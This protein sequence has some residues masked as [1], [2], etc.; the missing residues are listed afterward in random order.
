VNDEVSFG[1]WIRRRRKSLDLTQKQLAERV[2]CAT[3]TIVKIEADERRPSREIAQLLAERLEIPAE[4]RS[5]F[6]RVARRERRVA[7]L[8]SPDVSAATLRSPVSAPATSHLPVPPTPLIG[9]ERELTAIHQMLHD[10]HCRLLTLTGPGGMGKT[11]LALETARQIAQAATSEEHSF[12]DGIHFVSLAP[13]SS[14]E[15]V[16][17]AIG[18]AIG[19]V[20]SESSALDVQLLNY[21]HSKQMLLV[22]DN[23]EHLLDSA[24]TLAEILRHASAIRVLVTSRER[25]NLQGEWVFEV[26]GL[27]VPPECQADRLGTYSAVTLFLQ[28]AQRVRPG[29]SLTPDECPPIVHIC[30][31]VEGMPLGIEL[32]AAWV[33]VLSCG[34]IAQ[35]IQRNLD[36]LTTSAR[37]VP[38]RHRSLQATMDHSW[39]LLSLDERGVLSRLSVF[40]GSF[41][42]E[43]AEQVAGATLPLLSALVDKSLLRR[44]EAGRYDLHELI[45]QYAQEQLMQ[46]GDF[47]D[48]RDRHLT[49]FLKFAEEA[50]PKLRDAK[51]LI[52]LDLLEQDHDNLRAALDWS[53]RN[54]ETSPP[55]SQASLRLAGTLYVFWKRRDHWSEGREWLQRA[56]AQSTDLPA[57]REYVRALNAAVQLA[58]EQADTRWAHQLAEENLALSREMGDTYSLACALSSLSLVLWKRKEYADARTFGEEGLAL[59]RELGDR[60]AVAESL[61]NLGHIAINQD[62]HAVAQSYLDESL[63]ICREI[64]NEIG[65]TEALG[66][67]GL[68]AYLR[69]DYAAA[70]SYLEE[71]LIRFREAASVPGIESA[72]NRLGDLARCQGDYDQAGQLYTESLALYREMGD[73]DE[74]PSLLHNLGYVAHHRG[75]YAKAIS[76]FRQGLMI[77][78]EVGNQAGIAECL[79]GIAGALI[80]HGEAERGARLLGAAEVLRESVGATMWPA[81]RIE[82]DRILAR[83]H[84]VLD[85]A[86]VAVL[87]TEGRAM[88]MPEAIEMVPA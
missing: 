31:L 49:F 23:F 9:R 40:R 3:A 35:E 17:P 8:A 48:A 33:R 47:D 88:S 19:L 83:L 76:Y 67:L 78:Q 2:G 16:V 7:A 4:E 39:N 50:E 69:N 63:S 46:A 56:L 86:T 59:F 14:V 81:N 18:E 1:R 79:T 55:S 62:D 52:W 44:L 36:F 82:Y 27:P 65:I 37:D 10:P 74:I 70:R 51:Q 73:K 75:D 5:E 66:D 58:V 26:Q 71:S 60:F 61:H 87:W 30:R 53:L 42:R 25:L 41:H 45:R 32:A 84:E 12:V 43:A 11:R 20:P 21:L 34:E 38:E 85:E 22:L 6:M 29:F 80:G 77:H 72:L 68:L 28:C 13:I 15:F 57:T 54:K 64:Q 24:R